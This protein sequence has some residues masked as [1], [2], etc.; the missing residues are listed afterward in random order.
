MDDL[1]QEAGTGPDGTSLD[2]LARAVRKR[3]LSAVGVQVTP[4]ALRE[5]PLPAIALADRHYV[6]VEAA[7]RAGV[8]VRDRGKRER[9]S[10]AAWNRRWAGVLLRLQPRAARNGTQRI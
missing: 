5:Q 10:W 3:G 6:L 9:L 2:A 7:D 4:E 1:A 8:V